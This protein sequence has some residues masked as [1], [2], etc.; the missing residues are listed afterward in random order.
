VIV[1]GK[2]N[3]RTPKNERRSKEKGFVNFL[4]SHGLWMMYR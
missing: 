4:S 3:A 2:N 1:P